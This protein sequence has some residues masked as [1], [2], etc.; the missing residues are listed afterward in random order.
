[1]KMSI[2]GDKELDRI[3]ATLEPRVQK[4]IE[5]KAARR[6]AKPVLKYARGYAPYY[7]GD[8][9]ASIK[10]RGLQKSK[11]KNVVGVS[12][13]TNDKSIFEGETYYGGFQEFGTA[14]MEPN[15]F[16][17]PAAI[18]AEPES[19]AIFRVEIRSIVLSEAKK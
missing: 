15:P 8:L 16:L 1:M 12:V 17:R 13:M 2:T 18:A 19:V 5:R 4:R 7:S 3:L 9:E 11:R 10:I 6:A 14:F